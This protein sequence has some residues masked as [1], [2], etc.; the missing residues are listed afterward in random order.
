MLPQAGDMSSEL[1]IQQP[2]SQA[3]GPHF[4]S[5]ETDCW[6]RETTTET[7]PQGTPDH[8]GGARFSNFFQPHEYTL[9]L[10]SPF[11][12]PYFGQTNCTALDLKEN[13]STK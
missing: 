6:T 1:I 10:L 7:K 13:K 5:A 8:D 12:N 11:S 2:P 9:D 4:V 3:S